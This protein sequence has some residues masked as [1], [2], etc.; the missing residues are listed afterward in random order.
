MPAQRRR[1]TRDRVARPVNGEAVPARPKAWRPKLS[2]GL[3]AVWPAE[4]TVV[5]PAPPIDAGLTDAEPT[6]AGLIDPRGRRYW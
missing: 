1:R 5:P 4:R 3:A 2:D 6:D